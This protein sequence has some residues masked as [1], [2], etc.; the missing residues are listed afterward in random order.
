MVLHPPRRRPRCPGRAH[1]GRPRPR[2]VPFHVPASSLAFP[3]PL[4]PVRPEVHAQ[5][6][7]SGPNSAHPGHPRAMHTPPRRCPAV[8]KGRG[9]LPRGASLGTGPS[10]AR[11]LAP[12]QLASPASRART[13]WPKR[14]S[15]T[16]LFLA[17][18]FSSFLAI[19]SSS[20]SRPMLAHDARRTR[21]AGA[22]AGPRGAGGAE[23]EE[24]G[25]RRRRACSPRGTQTHAA[26]TSGGGGVPPPR[27]R[28]SEAGEG[29]RALNIDLKDSSGQRLPGRPVGPPERDGAAREGSPSAPPGPGWGCRREARGGGLSDETRGRRRGT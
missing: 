10:P 20:S 26:H 15:L 13:R 21:G 4:G 23:E 18:I 22:A 28:A 29:W 9:S 27:P 7:S 8:P 5:A 6:S 3:G 19:L 25:R 24:A 14:R 16:V 1:A 12:R 11:L 17:T 2:K